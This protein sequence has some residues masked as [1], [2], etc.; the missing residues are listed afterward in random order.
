[1]IFRKCADPTGRSFTAKS[2]PEVRS[3]RVSSATRIL[4][5]ENFREVVA[6]QSP[7]AIIAC[8]HSRPIESSMVENN[9]CHDTLMLSNRKYLSITNAPKFC[10]TWNDESNIVDIVIIFIEYS[11]IGSRVPITCFYRFRDFYKTP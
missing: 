8:Y 6:T 10:V 3:L 7:N 5:R 2:S 11:G 9:T 4:R 1:M